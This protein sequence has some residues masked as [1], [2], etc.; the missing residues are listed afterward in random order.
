MIKI[1]RTLPNI[2]NHIQCNLKDS[3][4]LHKKETYIKI[5]INEIKFDNELWEKKTPLHFV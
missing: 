1:I 5:F 2:K 4:I 3:Y